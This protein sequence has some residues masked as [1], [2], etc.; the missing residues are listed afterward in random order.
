MR[1]SAG[2]WA[3]TRPPCDLEQMLHLFPHQRNFSN[4]V[5]PAVGGSLIGMHMDVNSI[6]KQKAYCTKH[7]A[8]YH[9]DSE[10]KLGSR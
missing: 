5:L 3:L 10:V 9:H 7:E 8:H 1:Q 4:P 2:A 6:K